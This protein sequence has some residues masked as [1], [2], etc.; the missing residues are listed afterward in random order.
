MLE[1]LFTSKSRIKILEYLFFYNEETYLREMAKELKLS[2]STTKRELDNLI[3]FGLIR[4]QGNRITFNK[5]NPIFDDLKNIFLKT[6]SIGYN[7]IN[8]LKN[9]DIEFI[10]LFG[11]FAHGKYSPESDVDLLIVGNVK[12]QE[13]FKLLRPVEKLI[14]REIAPVVWTLEELKKGKNGGFVRDIMK[15]NKIMLKGDKNEFQRIIR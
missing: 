1:K 9:E 4:K 6:D 12:Q 7:I 13:V 10:V 3:N 14:K 11:S 15:K 5:S 2:P 8:A